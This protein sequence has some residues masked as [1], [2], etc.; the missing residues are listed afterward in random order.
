MHP[1]G[2]DITTVT[3]DGPK[4]SCGNYG[5][6]ETTAS[7]RGWHITSLFLFHEFFVAA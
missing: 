5:C 7:D 6:V 2:S 4:C 1:L 3:E